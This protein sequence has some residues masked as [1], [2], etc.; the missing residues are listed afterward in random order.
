MY[1]FVTSE[2]GMEGCGEKVTM[3]EE[4]GVTISARENFYAGAD[5]RNPRCADEDHLQ[6][7]AGEG[8]RQLQDG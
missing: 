8:S 1:A 7:A 3:A 4:N 5:R 6:V 2:F